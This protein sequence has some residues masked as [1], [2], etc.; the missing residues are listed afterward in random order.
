MWRRLGVNPVKEEVETLAQENARLKEALRI[1][2]NAAA[3]YQ[4]YLKTLEA[5]KALGIEL[6]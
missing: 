1:A 6:D 4:D 3:S 5:I 2:M